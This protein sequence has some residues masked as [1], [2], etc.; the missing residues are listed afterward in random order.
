M[1]LNFHDKVNK[2]TL[3]CHTFPCLP[4]DVVHKPTLKH[5]YTFVC[6]LEE[7]CLVVQFLDSIGR[8]SKLITR[9]LLETDDFFNSSG[10]N[11]EKKNKILPPT[12]FSYTSSPL[13]TTAATLSQSEF[14]PKKNLCR[15]KAQMHKT[16]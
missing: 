16:E 4:S 10:Q 8:M 2:L 5:P 11:T 6:F 13:E 12:V 9:Y 14:C 1:S 7:I 15:K 3:E